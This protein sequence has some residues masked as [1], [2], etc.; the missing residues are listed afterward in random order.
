MIKKV[1]LGKEQLIEGKDFIFG[2]PKIDNK[3]LTLESKIQSMLYDLNIAFANGDRYCSD[4]M[5][6]DI[7]TVKEFLKEITKGTY[8]IK[9]NNDHI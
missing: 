6:E 9:K 5:E 3:F 1:F 8:I 4:D 7:K 2:V